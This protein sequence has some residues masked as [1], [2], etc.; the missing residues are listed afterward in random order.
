MDSV[1]ASIV[2]SRLMADRARLHMRKLAKSIARANEVIQRSMKVIGEQS[3][4]RARE[5]TPGPR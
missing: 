4:D 2:R 5:S 3:P 1:V